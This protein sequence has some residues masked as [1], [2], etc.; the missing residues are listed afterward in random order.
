MILL[1]DTGNTRIKWAVLGDHG[2]GTQH[3]DTYAGWGAVQLRARVLVPAGQI[4]RVLV[5]N[6]GGEKIATLVRE[7]ISETWGLQPEFLQASAEACGVRNGY[8]NPQQLGTDRWAAMIGAYALELRP[9]CV[10][11]VGTAMTIDGVDVNGQHL[12]GVIVPGPDLMISSLMRNT[13]DIAIRSQD[14]RLGEGLF[15]DNT[16]GAVYQGAVN[17]LSAL[18][19]QAMTTMTQQ[20]AETPTLLMTGGAADRLDRLVSRPIRHVPNLVL[21]G[22]AVLAGEARPLSHAP[23]AV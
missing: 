7:T 10:V 13:S 15:A 16:L 6:V 5:S 3:A 21:R 11:N 22:L 18:V 17:A 19:E 12:G 20:C 23:A 4:D 9:V 14:G 2:L 8:T 1:I